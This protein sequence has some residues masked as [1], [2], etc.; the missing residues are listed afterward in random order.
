MFRQEHN[1]QELVHVTGKILMKADDYLAYIGITG[2]SPD[3]TLS[4]LKKLQVNHLMHIPFENLDIQYFRKIELNLELFYKKFLVSKRGG[5][6]Y[7]LNGLFSWLLKKEGFQVHLISARVFNGKKIP[8]PEFDHLTLCVPVKNKAYLV[9][10]GFGDFS[11]KPLLIQPDLEQ[12]D[13][14]GVFVIRQVE[15]DSYCVEKRQGRSFHPQYIFS[16]KPYNLEDFQPMNHFHQTSSE[17][18]FTQKKICSVMT[19]SGRIT[20]TNNRL[21]ISDDGKKTQKTLASENEFNQT[22]EKYFGFRMD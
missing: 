19:K 12:K 1:P 15:N 3:P 5:Y 22:L 13:Q 18:L 8:G 17:S 9:D 6:C 21:I 16:L 7:E 20:L 14:N 11:S 4:Y 10:V 2:K